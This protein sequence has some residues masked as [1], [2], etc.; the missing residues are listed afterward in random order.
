M[1]VNIEKKHLYATLSVL[2]ILFSSL[3]VIAQTFTTP[4]WDSSKQSHDVLYTN[5]I[6]SKA[7]TPRVVKVDGDLEVVS[8]SGITLGGVKQTS[9]PTPGSPV[10]PEA[11]R[12]VVTEAS[13]IDGGSW[14]TNLLCIDNYGNPDKNMYCVNPT[15][16]TTFGELIK[17]WCNALTGAG[18]TIELG[19]V[20][21]AQ[22]YSAGTYTSGGADDVKHYGLYLYP[23]GTGSLT[24]SGQSAQFVDLHN[25]N[26]YNWWDPYGG[27]SV[28]YPS[29]K[30]CE[31]KEVGPYTF[32]T[33]PFTSDGNN[34][35]V[36]TINQE[37]SSE[38][39]CKLTICKK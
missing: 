17:D 13:K 24:T 12:C 28:S 4:A 7:S 31:F 14:I 29:I 15:S 20:F 10:S 27:S 36:L 22:Q 37:G 35:W 30:G 11:G 2:V 38:V 19:E 25:G 34:N 21:D 3:Y 33:D 26:P 6:T 9:W 18:C 32:G 16:Y 5:T 39:A 8:G 23:A 1:Q